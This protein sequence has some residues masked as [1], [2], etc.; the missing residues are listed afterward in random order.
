MAAVIRTDS[1]SV[2][3]SVQVH[4]TVF[5]EKTSVYLAFWSAS[6]YLIAGVEFQAGCRSKNTTEMMLR[7][8]DIV[9]ADN[10]G[11]TAKV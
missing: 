5:A 3:F 10:Y 9:K 1:L 7:R 11:N 4:L 8:Q 6:L 2:C